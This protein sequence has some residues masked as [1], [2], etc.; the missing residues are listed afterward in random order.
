LTRAFRFDFFLVFLGWTQVRQLVG[1]DGR[2]WLD[3]V[4][5]VSGSVVGC[6]HGDGS[7]LDVLGVGAE[8]AGAGAGA[9]TGVVAVEPPAGEAG[10]VDVVPVVAPEGAATGDADGA[11]VG[12]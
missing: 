4:V 5:V 8:S 9:C 11:G 1:D 10:A 12:C 3:G 2:G 7:E 6:W